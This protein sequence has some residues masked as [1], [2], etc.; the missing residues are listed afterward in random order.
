MCRITTIALTSVLTMTFAAW[1]ASGGQKHQSPPKSSGQGQSSG[2]HQN[3][4]G[5]KK[6]SGGKEIH[7]DHGGVHTTPPKNPNPPGKTTGI[8]KTLSRSLKNVADNPKVGTGAQTAINNFQS[9]GFLSATDRQNLND[10]VAGNPARLGEDDLKAVQAA[11]DFDALAKREEQY[12]RLENATGERLTVWVHY[13]ILADKD[14]FEWMPTKPVDQ[15]KALRYVVEP[16]TTTYFSNDGARIAAARVR[17]WAESDS[18]TKWTT[19]RDQDYKLKPADRQDVREMSTRTLKL[20]GNQAS[21][22]QA[23]K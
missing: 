1:T 2:Q 7:K 23:A 13:Q 10:L 11:L 9:G 3:K 21:G 4:T 8:R 12:I 14:A 16:N 17:L 19:Y 5:G 22:A 6:T 15:E 20:V 18:G